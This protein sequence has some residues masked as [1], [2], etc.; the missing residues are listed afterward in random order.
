MKKQYEISGLDC[1]NCANKLM[2]KAKKEDYID[3][4]D[5]NFVMGKMKLETTDE[6]KALNFL[7]KEEK[8]LIVKS[9]KH[10]HNHGHDHEHGDNEGKNLVIK[11]I[12]SLILI[13]F[14][15]FVND[16]LSNIILIITY[17][18][19]GYE[20][21]YKAIT[22]LLKGNLFDEF[23][24]MFIATF[25]ALTIGEYIEAVIVMYFY[26]LGEYFQSLAINN[27]RNSIKGLLE[28]QIKDVKV[29]GKGI[30]DPK[31]IEV[32]DIIELNVG[33]KLPVDAI[34]LSDVYMNT[35]ALTGESVPKKYE[36]NETVLASMILDNKSSRFEVINDYDNST[37]SKLIQL[38]EDAN[39]N[40]SKT[41]LFITRFS[42]IYTPI[43]V[44]LAVLLVLILPFFGFT[45]D[46]AIYRA[47]ILLVISC[48]CALVISVPLGYFTT[49]GKSTS[50]GILIKGATIVDSINKVDTLIMDKTGTLTKGNFVVNSYKNYSD[51]KEEELFNIVA[52]AELKSNHPIAKSIVSFYEE[53]YS[54]NLS[55]F[56]IEEIKGKGLKFEYN[57]EEV[58]IGKKDLLVSNG[59]EIN[60]NSF[61][62][63][64]I[65]VSIDKKHVLTIDIQDQ[66]KEEA[67]DV[68]NSL[69]KGGIKEVIML[70]GDN[71]KTAQKIAEK[72]NIDEF[73]YNLLPEDKLSILKSKQTDDN[74]LAFIG[75]G[76]N[77]A[78]VISAAD[79]GISM[80]KIGSDVTI[81]SSDVV[82][83]NDSLDSLLKLKKTSKKGLKIIKQ[84]L[85]F[86]IIIKVV[87]IILGIFGIATMFEAIFTDVGV[88]ILAILNTLRILRD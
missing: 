63:S 5:I 88:T 29:E 59:I 1:Q 27:S 86:A 4:I 75:D 6:K 49:I 22:N 36:E 19:I 3:S 68:L 20:V 79:V 30:V 87:F 14:S 84:N 35:A 47:V 32:G 71:Q 15:F 76:I 81:E 45:Y 33:D 61:D 73:Y 38:V 80:G 70:T 16:K 62:G 23:F 46:E 48:P 41:E 39:E 77:D 53:N 55:K 2:E 44:L 60:E 69:Q 11:L 51:I 56:D 40:K 78:P 57:N 43:V 65:Y 31:K 54:K 18:I 74:T 72:L 52:S 24:L 17:I 25:A 28:A 21:I 83:N 12:I 66:L 64:I 85:F 26:M 13:I 8:S 67:A 7:K 50:Q 82:V 58:L 9:P 37:I 42:K 34:T 10:D